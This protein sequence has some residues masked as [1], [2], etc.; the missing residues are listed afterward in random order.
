M[1]LR[2]TLKEIKIKPDIYQRVKEGKR[3]GT[4]KKTSGSYERR[5]LRS[6]GAV[7]GPRGLDIVSHGAAT[8]VAAPGSRQQRAP[9]IPEPDKGGGE[10]EEYERE[11][12]AGG[13]EKPQL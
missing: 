13:E 8:R 3:R 9:D 12:E 11:C 1:K 2:K 10:V 6:R 4:V 5:Q 7:R